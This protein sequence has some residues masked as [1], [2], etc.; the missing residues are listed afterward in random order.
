M[1]WL[2]FSIGVLFGFMLLEYGWYA[3]RRRKHRKEELELSRN[4]K[5]WVQNEHGHW[6]PKDNHRKKDGE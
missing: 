5:E 6:L 4:P 1:D 3:R 2:S